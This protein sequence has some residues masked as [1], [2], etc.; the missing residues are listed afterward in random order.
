MDL[1]RTWKYWSNLQKGLV[2]GL[3]ASLILAAITFTLYWKSKQPDL[4][5]TMKLTVSDGAVVVEENGT[6]KSGKGGIRFQSGDALSTGA[7]SVASVTLDTGKVITL[8]ENSRVEFSKSDKTYD[9]R[10]SS[11]GFFFGLDSALAADETLTL[12]TNNLVVSIRDT[13]GYFFTDEEGNDSLLI[14]SG[15]VSVRASNSK[16]GEM[17]TI[18]ISAGQIVTVYVDETK[19]EDS[20]DFGVRDLIEEELPKFFVEQLVAD[21]K[22]LDRVCE[23]T[24][25]DKDKL[26]KIS[27]GEIKKLEQDTAVLDARRIPT[28]TPLATATP[29]PT[30][31][32]TEEADPTSGDPTPTKKPKKTPTPAPTPNAAPIDT[33]TPVPAPTAAPVSTPTPAPT[34]ET[35]ASMAVKTVDLVI[36]AGQSNMS[37]RGGN[38]KAAPG[39][40]VDTGYEFRIGTCPTGLYPVTEPFGVYSN[41]YL[42]DL[43]ILR[44]GSLVSA[45]MNSYYKATGVPV[46]GFS[47]ARGGSSIG[48]WQTA[49]VQAELSQKFDTIKGC[50]QIDQQLVG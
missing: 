30:A 48:Y 45:F 24:G 43:P 14:T 6:S 13:S 47:A 49:P 17:K 10:L 39:V 16:T 2:I 15:T 4:T 36:F 20:I 41:G 19:N 25:W 44:G 46:M 18:E 5:N 9:V 50:M 21:D 33:P 40:P 31:E 12:R 8:N 1:K 37:G 42:C 35:S 26:L 38:A 11:G 23:S 34:A 27:S 29:Q 32:P 28:P 22:A 7:S 3:I